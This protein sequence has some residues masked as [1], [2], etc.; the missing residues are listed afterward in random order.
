MLFQPG[1]RSFL[2]HADQP[3]VAGD[4]GGEEWQLA[5]ALRALCPCLPVSGI[6]GQFTSLPKRGP[7]ADR[8]ARPIIWEHGRPPGIHPTPQGA[9]RW[10]TNAML[11]A[12]KH[13]AGLRLA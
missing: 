4:I 11:S 5:V 7:A 9:G 12:R 6:G 2:V 13:A 3:T 8:E 1:V 10:V